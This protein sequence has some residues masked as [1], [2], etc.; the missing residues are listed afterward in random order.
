METPGDVHIY[1]TASEIERLTGRKYGKYQR[2][3][4]AERGWT[5][6]VDA[7]G[8]PLVLRQLHDARLGAKTSTAKR[9]RGPRLE[10]LSSR[11]GGG[12]K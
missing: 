5:F 3:V 12:P 10:G 7:D 2:Q 8:R 9:A 6:E 11:C 1:L 4:L